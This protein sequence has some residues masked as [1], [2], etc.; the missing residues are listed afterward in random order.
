MPAAGSALVSG[1]V[2]AELTYRQAIAAFGEEGTA[3]LINLAGLYCMVSVTLN[4]FDEQISLSFRVAPCTT[5]QSRPIE[6]RAARD[7]FAQ[8]AMTIRLTV[9]PIP[10]YSLPRLIGTE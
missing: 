9:V 2:L 4:G 7:C 5:K 10:F 8:L 6:R 1:G 3:E